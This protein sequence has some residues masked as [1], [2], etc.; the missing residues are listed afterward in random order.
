MYINIH[1]GDGNASWKS[2]QYDSRPTVSKPPRVSIRDQPTLDI[3][4]LPNYSESGNWICNA[5][6][7]IVGSGAGGGTVAA[8]LVKA[9]YSVIVLEKGGI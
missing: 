9:G 2:I 5:D 4:P 7:V 8:D 6:V 3:H 1:V